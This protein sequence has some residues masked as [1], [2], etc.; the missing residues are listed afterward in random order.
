MACIL[1]LGPGLNAVSLPVITNSLAQKLVLKVPSLLHVSG[2]SG[3]VSVAG[4]D[5]PGS[6]FLDGRLAG[7]K[8]LAGLGR[9]IG[10]S[11][12]VVVVIVVASA[13]KTT[14]FTGLPGV[15]RGSV[16]V[17]DTLGPDTTSPPVVGVRRPRGMLVY[18]AM[19]PSEVTLRSETNCTNSTLLLV[20]M[21]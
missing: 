3:F 17:D 16:A 5:T 21:F 1:P 19:N 10:C 2:H 6:G 7:L 20:I 12:V 14:G 9:A 13:V 8:G 18:D 11:V 15:T 4:L